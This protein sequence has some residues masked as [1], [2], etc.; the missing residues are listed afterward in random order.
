MAFSQVLYY[1]RIDISD[2]TWLKTALLYWDSVRTIVPESI[3]TPY[4]S[5]TALELAEAGFLVPLRVHSGMEEIEELTPDVLTYLNTSEGL[6]LL[7]GSPVGARDHI[8]VE[9]LPYQLGRL[10][11]IHP[12]KLP[13]EVRHMIERIG[14]R[15]HR[16]DE[17][18]EVDQPFALFY[19]TLL[20]SRLAERVGAGLLTPMPAAEQLAVA[21][22]LDAQLQ[23]IIPW[24]PA[25]PRRWREYEAFGTRRHMPRTLAPGMLA[26][27]AI[28]RIAIARETSV[29]S[30]MEFKRQHK[31]EL[32]QFRTKIGQLA[33]TVDANLPAEA[34]RQR[35]S[36][37]YTT[38]VEPA[39]K[40]L[41]KALDGRRVRWLGEGLLRIA[42]LSAASSSM[43]V[44]AGLATPTALLAGAGLSLIVSGTMYNVDKREALR[45]NPF[46][47]L[48]SAEKAL[49]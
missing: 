10:A 48:L 43:F 40:D 45:S 27:L 38:E 6:E 29:A 9:K 37:L 20:A 39:I 33:S 26:Q 30:L 11:K 16:A 25:G 32:A 41:K 24:N 15:S 4:S 46:T 47:Y 31:D 21:A 19:M 1:P 7:C 8:H 42:F 17:W 12:E 49:A 28:Q 14:S 35:V 5:D 23:G 3:E 13:Y 44:T 2:E 36:D 34:L 22:R 18:L